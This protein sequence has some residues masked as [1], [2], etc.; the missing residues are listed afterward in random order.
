M[1]RTFNYD[2]EYLPLPSPAPDDASR[3]AYSTTLRRTPT[4]DS[5][6][7]LVHTAEA[8]RDAGP[9][10]MIDK[11]VGAAKRLMGGGE[12][13]H[14]RAENGYAYASLPKERNDTAAARFSS[15]TPEVSFVYV[16]SRPGLIGMEDTASH[17]HT[18]L[19]SGLEASA[20]PSLLAQHG[21]NEFEVAAKEPAWLKFAKSV[22]ESPLI[23]LLCGSAAV[24]ALMGNYDDAIS[25]VLA[26]TIVLTGITTTV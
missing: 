5:F 19:T 6:G 8:I 14:E 24:S 7:R 13:R 1:Q 11:I 21:P 15:A 3:Y 17:F 20:I 9:G 12:D 4:D 10:G 16:Y 25:I 23:L 22:Y 2:G 26:V 18:S